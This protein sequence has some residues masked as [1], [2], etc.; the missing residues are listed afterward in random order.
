M[1]GHGK[2]VIV[3]DRIFHRCPECKRYIGKVRC[4]W[5][6]Q[7]FRTPHPPTMQPPEVSADVSAHR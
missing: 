5:C 2:Q 4:R 1:S 7:E 3:R 6:G